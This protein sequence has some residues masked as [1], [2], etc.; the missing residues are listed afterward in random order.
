MDILPLRLELLVA[1]L[2]DEE[3]SL[4]AL[5]DPACSEMVVFVPAVVI[6]S[7]NLAADSLALSLPVMMVGDADIAVGLLEA[8]DDD[9]SCFMSL[10]G[11]ETLFDENV[12][13]FWKCG[14]VVLVVKCRGL[15][16]GWCL[17]FARGCT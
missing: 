3:R 5:G 1:T 4:L 12:C 8:E 16:I 11:L 14:D 10:G 7:A 2:P 9:C 15:L 17:T 6:C 13:W